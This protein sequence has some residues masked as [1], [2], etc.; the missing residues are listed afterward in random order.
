M[1]RACSYI[2]GFARRCLIEDPH[3]RAGEQDNDLD[4]LGAAELLQVQLELGLADVDVPAC[5]VCYLLRELAEY[6]E[7]ASASILGGGE[8]DRES[9]EQIAVLVPLLRA[10]A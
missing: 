9:V 5:M 1:L 3:N 7:S 8:D 2:D 4:L 10:L 6:V